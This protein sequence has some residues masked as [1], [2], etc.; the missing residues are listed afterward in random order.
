M[1]SPEF[2]AVDIA[3]AEGE[4]DGNVSRMVRMSLYDGPCNLVEIGAH[5]QVTTRQTRWLV[6]SSFRSLAHM[7]DLIRLC[8]SLPAEH[9]LASL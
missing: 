1:L 9:T 8:S 7:A 6:V 2:R 3:L 4:Q 5:Q